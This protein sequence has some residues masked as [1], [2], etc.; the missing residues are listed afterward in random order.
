ML[1]PHSMYKNKLA[2]SG[3]DPVVD[4]LKGASYG[5]WE[6]FEPALDFIPR[7]IP[8][9][10]H[11]IVMW[12]AG[13]VLVDPEKDT[14]IVKHILVWTLTNLPLSVFILWYA[15]QSSRVLYLWA[16]LHFFLWFTA[17]DTYVLALHVISH[18]AVFKP[19]LATPIWHFYVSILGPIFGETPETY[20]VHHIGMHHSFNNFFNDLSCTM[21]YKRDSFFHWLRYFFRFLFCHYEMFK[22]FYGR[23]NKLILRFLTGECTWLCFVL[24]NYP[25]RPVPTLLVLVAPVLIMRLGMMAGNW[26]Q[27][28]F[29]NPSE[30]ATNMGHSINIIDSAYNRRC[31]N[32]GYHIIHHM[33][34]SAHYT[35]LP[36]LFK[37]ELPLLAEHDC[38]VFSNPK[39]D[40][41]IVWFY[42]MIKDYDTLAKNYVNIRSTPRTH[43]EI[44]AMLKAR[45]TRVYSMDE[46]L[47]NK[48][49]KQQ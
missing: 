2:C 22:L 3:G 7:V 49:Y 43:E 46:F 26:G 9:A 32:D 6:K 47:P 33:Y 8:E 16:I 12:V 42:L 30:P 31:F 48:E 14:L 25:S 4:P 27:H 45:A 37:Q 40:F 15:D 23:N 11:K 34:P 18:R 35:E 21:C 13:K 5:M 10:M 41:T 29:I 19:A 38:I 28:A 1:G 39:W 44:K 20:Y 17:M 24:Y 36:Q